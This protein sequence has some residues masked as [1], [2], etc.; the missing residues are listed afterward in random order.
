MNRSGLQTA[1]DIRLTGE[2]NY[3]RSR[4]AFSVALG[5]MAAAHF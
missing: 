2:P 3:I 5:R 4:I 1:G